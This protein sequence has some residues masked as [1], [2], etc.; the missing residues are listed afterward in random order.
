MTRYE[1]IHFKKMVRVWKTKSLLFCLKYDP[2]MVF[3][4]QNQITF[5]FIKMMSHDLLVQMAY[6]P[7]FNPLSRTFHQP[8]LIH[9]R[10]Y[11]KSSAS[12]S[13]RN[14]CFNLERL[15]RCF[16]LALPEFRIW[17]EFG[18][19]LIQIRDA[20][21]F[22]YRTKC[23]NYYNIFCKHFDRN[24]HF[25]PFELSSMSI[26]IGVWINSAGLNNLGRP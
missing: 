10:K 12:E 8:N 18:T 15:S 11:K 14:A 20:Q 6:W 21:L 22:M 24:E 5:I 16:C 2:L 3:W 26:M 23:I 7:F 17:R 19:P 9:W 4:G 25:S 13:L 1:L